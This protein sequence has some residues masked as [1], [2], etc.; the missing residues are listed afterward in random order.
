MILTSHCK[1]CGSQCDGSARD[2]QLLECNIWYLCTCTQK[3]KINVGKNLWW[4]LSCRMAQ[5]TSW[6]ILASRSRLWML[7][8]Y[9]SRCFWHRFFFFWLRT[10][11]TCGSCCLK[12]VKTWKNLLQL[13]LSLNSW[14]VFIYHYTCK[15]ISSFWSIVTVNAC[16]LEY[17]Q[18]LAVIPLSEIDCK[19]S[20]YFHGHNDS[21]MHLT[22]FS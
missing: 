13:L 12:L 8:W 3:R 21:K 10:R 1:L 2:S 19:Y 6:L 5:N 16:T 9:N 14:I 15:K 22:W 20:M 11:N 17:V 18:V 4:L 7:Y